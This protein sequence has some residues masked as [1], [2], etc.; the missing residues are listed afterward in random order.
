[1]KIEFKKIEEE[2]IATLEGEIFTSKSYIKII[3]E[4]HEGGSL[5]VCFGDGITEKEQANIKKMIT[6]INE[7]KNGGDIGIDENR[8]QSEDPLP[9]VDE[10]EIDIRGIP[11]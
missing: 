2:V 6:E 5:E 3:K 8:D 10:D 11:F 7:V 4:L 1:M 9:V